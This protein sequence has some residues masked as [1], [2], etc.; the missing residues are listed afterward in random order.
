MAKIKVTQVR[1]RINRP[2]N[3]KLTLDA[4]GL[5]KNNQSVEH[6]DSPQILGM[7]N[8]VKHLVKVDKV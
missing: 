6:E 8:K 2:R 4:L 5:K 3:Q 1:S 7:I